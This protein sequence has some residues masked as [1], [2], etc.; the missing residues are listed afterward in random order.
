MAHIQ[1]PTFKKVR[2]QNILNTVRPQCSYYITCSPIL[3]PHQ[4]VSSYP[5]NIDSAGDAKYKYKISRV[6][7][8]MTNHKVYVYVSYLYRAIFIQFRN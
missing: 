8:F 5:K 3:I 7:R 2:L 1:N 6:R 4:V